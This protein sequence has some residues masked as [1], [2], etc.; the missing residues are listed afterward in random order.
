MNI[1][2]TENVSKQK[3]D[4][5]VRNSENGYFFHT[6][7]WAKI[8]EETYGYQIATRLYKIEG[9][10]VLIP[11]MEGKKYG[12]YYYDSIPLGYGG[13]FSTSDIPSEAFQKILKNIVGGRHLLF[14]LSL[15]P[16]SNF[17]I[18]E[19]S[20]IRQVNSEWNYTH[21]LSLE[22]GFEYLWK[23]KFKQ[24]NRTA[25]RKAEKN[26]IEILNGNSLQNF[27][28]YYELYVETS[29]RWG[30]KKPQHPLRLY[31]N[32]CKF[33]LPHVQLR[34]A[35]KDDKVIA[36]LVSFYYSKIVF[37]WGSALLE[38][39]ADK[40]PTNLLLKD[41]IEHACEEGYKYYNFGAS[42]N[43]DGVRKF[44]EGFGAERVALKKYRAVSRL[45]GLVSKLLR[46]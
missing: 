24:T 11:I 13:I 36:G 22:K 39:Y 19:D 17:S 3:W 23:N 44:K 8:L 25:V 2:Y 5:I 14:G 40:R 10:E 29:K 15:P 18:R 43:L 32:M 1:E 41:S 16:F 4:E 45:G 38:E 35:V 33:G 26:R 7:A 42:G 30:Y 12:F 6:P 27:R 20:S 34:L 9:N 46:R 28:E 31:E 21:V 37:Y